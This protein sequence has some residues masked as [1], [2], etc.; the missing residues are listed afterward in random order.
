MAKIKPSSLLAEIRGTLGGIVFSSNTHGYYCKPLKI[1]VQP[2][3]EYQTGRRAVFSDAVRSYSAMTPVQIAAWQ[4]FAA[5]PT[6]TRYDYFGDA[7]L[8]SAL[9][10]YA[11]INML[12]NE[13]GLTR[14]N[15]APTGALPNA[16]PSM[17]VFIDF[18]PSPTNSYIKR[19]AAFH[20]SIAYV[21]VL[22]R[23]WA[24]LGRTQ[25]PLPLYFLDIYP[26]ASFPTVDIQADLVS[27][28]GDLPADGNWYLTLAPVSSELRI[29]TSKTYS[30][31]SGDT[32][33]G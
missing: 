5:D 10:Q 15:T 27:C 21:H 7:Y 18:V 6:N 23:L 13:A 26:A 31:R 32:V 2:R 9:N 16:L 12:R 19:T 17:Q 33:T 28:F 4:A 22:I 11:S 25:P 8:P 14:T 3:T 1:P 20:A 30:G 24:S 29:G